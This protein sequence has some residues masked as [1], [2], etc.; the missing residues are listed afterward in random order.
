MAGTEKSEI[1]KVEPT[2]AR[3]FTEKYSKEGFFNRSLKLIGK[4]QPY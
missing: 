2:R 4:L 1:I 3:R